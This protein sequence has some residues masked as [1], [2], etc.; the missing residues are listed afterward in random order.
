LPE[1]RGYHG[2]ETDGAPKP[3]TH[4]AMLSRPSRYCTVGPANPSE[5]GR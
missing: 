3:F 5:C 1:C 2:G 4:F